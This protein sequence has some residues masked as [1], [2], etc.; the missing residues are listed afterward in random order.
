MLQQFQKIKNSEN[1]GVLLSLLLNCDEVKNVWKEKNNQRHD[2]NDKTNNYPLNQILYGPPGTGKTYNVI[3]KALEIIALK[4]EELRN[5]LNENPD[6]KALK[7]KFEEFRKAGQIEFITFHQ[8]FSYEEFVE[9]LKPDIDSEEIKYKI[10]DGVFKKL[11]KKAK[12]S[13]NFDEIYNKLLDEI[14][15]GEKEFKTKT[16]KHFRI[17]VNSRGNL[18]LMTGAEFR[19]QGTITK[20]NLKSNNF[21]YW[22]SYTEPI[23]NYLKSIGWKTSDNSNKNYVLIIDEINRGNI[24]KI[25]GELITLIEESKRLGSNEE[26]KITL[27]YSKEEFGVPSNLYI[28][29]AMNTADRSIALMDTALRRRFTFIEMMPEYDELNEIDGINLSQM[30]KT[31]N[32]R[33]EYLYDREHTIGHAYFINIKDFDELKN[34]FRNKIIPLLA[35]YFYEDWKKIRLVLGDFQKEEKYQFVKEKSI[36]KK[37]FPKDFNFDDKKIY[38]INEEAFTY[39][40]SYIGI[41][42]KL[43]NETGSSS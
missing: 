9:G 16:G 39:F 17:K 23:L 36:D 30:L 6:R 7:E 38:E 41:Y 4:D 37:L 8:S 5:F 12:I 24:S 33:I 13:D 21:N 43:E 15:E 26:I 40:K 29:G 28:I 19:E 31:M 11:C 22:K 25:F 14:G 20:E 2:M 42:K 18:T 3:K 27:P 34:V 10:E 35:E 32:E 1:M